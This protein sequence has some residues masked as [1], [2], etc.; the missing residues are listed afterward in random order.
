MTGRNKVNTRSQAMNPFP[1]E[2]QT[3]TQESSTPTKSPVLKILNDEEAGIEWND[4]DLDFLT[5]CYYSN[6]S[7]QLFSFTN[8]SL[9][10]IFQSQLVL[11]C[12]SQ[13]DDRKPTILVDRGQV[14][15]HALH[16]LRLTPPPHPRRASL[17]RP[18]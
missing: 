5:V 8:K 4:E 10:F 14:P 18:P 6:G 2:T 17:H 7:L 12:G 1:Q 9:Q 15:Q 3:G 16:R 11:F 13:V